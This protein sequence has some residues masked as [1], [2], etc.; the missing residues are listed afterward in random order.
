L[1]VIGEPWLFGINTDHLAEQQVAGFLKENGLTLAT[2]EPLGSKDKR[3][4]QDG[5]FVLAANG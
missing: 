1:K 5:G 2:F 3:D 4:R